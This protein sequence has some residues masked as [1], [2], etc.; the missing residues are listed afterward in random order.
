MVSSY[1]AVC[2]WAGSLSGLK[3]TP[4]G[5]ERRSS[6]HSLNIH[7]GG[8]CNIL[9]SVQFL[10]LLLDWSFCNSVRIP[11]SPPLEV[12]KSHFSHDLQTGGHQ[13]LS[14]NWVFSGEMILICFQ[15]ATKPNTYTKP[16]PSLTNASH[17]G[18]GSLASFSGFVISA[19]SELWFPGSCLF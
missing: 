2:C 12:M 14:S 1:W 6:R 9:G 8:K 10:K 5:T 11:S 19:A 18:L 7:R 15:A 13:S 16:C 4:L 17:F 3:Q